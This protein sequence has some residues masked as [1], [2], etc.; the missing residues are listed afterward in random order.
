MSKSSQQAVRH[1]PRTSSVS[2][3][4]TQKTGWHFEEHKC[5]RQPD[6]IANWSGFHI[7]LSEM[8][9]TISQG[10]LAS[11]HVVMSRNDKRNT[12]SVAGKVAQKKKCTRYGK[13]KN[14]NL[15]KVM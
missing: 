6:Q 1:S 15:P 14:G 8:S 13:P 4:S 2:G 12:N 9:V 5:K 7:D 3:K 11:L 10:T